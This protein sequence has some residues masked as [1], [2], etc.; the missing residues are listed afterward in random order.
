MA[1]FLR[2]PCVLCFGAA[3][4]FSLFSAPQVKAEAG[5]KYAVEVGAFPDQAAAS[6]AAASFD[7]V[8]PRI[9]VV[10]DVLPYRLR[11]GNFESFAEAWVVRE[12]TRS[13]ADDPQILVE[14]GDE[15]TT[16]SAAFFHPFDLSSAGERG[17][18]SKGAPFA[19]VR[20]EA[21]VSPTPTILAKNVSEMTLDELISTASQDE[22]YLQQTAALRR[23][24]AD[25]PENHQINRIKL[26]LSRKEMA[27]KD[28]TAADALLSQV[29]AEGTPAEAAAARYLKAYV[30][31][32]REGSRHCFDDFAAVVADPALPDEAR[33]DAMRRA[34]GSA[35]AAKNHVE[36]WLAFD[37]LDK[38]AR[39][40]DTLAEAKM[41]KAG[42]AYEIAGLQVLSWDDITSDTWSEVRAACRAVR[43]VPGAPTKSVATADLMHMETWFWQKE[44]IQA[45]DEAEDLIALSAA[46]SQSRREY[47]EARSWKAIFLAKLGR[48]SEAKPLFE[49][50]MQWE[51][52]ESDRFAGRH[53]KAIAALWLAWYA[54]AE[55]DTEAE[56]HYLR[57]L[58]N[59]YASY[60]QV[61]QAREMF[62]EERF[63][64]HTE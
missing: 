62:G 47:N 25:H 5:R 41:Q 31:L 12:K 56:R 8:A 54:F 44:Y 2:Q 48:K 63:L 7:P 53:P 33:L 28:Y 24:L 9:E 21:A 43:D 52:A 36:A 27:L 34:A 11:F 6:A 22:V 26:R 38:W 46:D 42:L 1:R 20:I 60:P 16:T 61:E 18:L 35:H 32:H 15:A 4:C 29:E 40:S 37:Q 45:L 59:D 13:A 30:K 50:I 58:R 17:P 23:L 39:D 64:L 49:E 51:I 57:L 3:F 19:H 10:P 14:S 55:K